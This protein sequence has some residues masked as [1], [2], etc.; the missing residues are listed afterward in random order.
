MCEPDQ[1]DGSHFSESWEL[2]EF[3]KSSEDKET[4]QKYL[5]LVKMFALGRI[6]TRSPKVIKSRRA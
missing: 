3:K 5:T 2:D 4:V 6:Q 1:L